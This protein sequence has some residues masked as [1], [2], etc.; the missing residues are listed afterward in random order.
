MIFGSKKQ[1]NI[2]FLNT[3]NKTE[4]IESTTVSN[5]EKPTVVNKPVEVPSMIIDDEIKFET[6]AEEDD[7]DEEIVKPEIQSEEIEIKQEEST[8]VSSEKIYT[9][10]IHEDVPTTR[11]EY[12]EPVKPDYSQEYAKYNEELKKNPTI[13]IIEEKTKPIQGISDDQFFDDFFDDGE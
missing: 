9:E 7:N 10:V 8:P 1:L 5:Y 3:D 11:T 13:E 6:D 4:E 2:T 12:V